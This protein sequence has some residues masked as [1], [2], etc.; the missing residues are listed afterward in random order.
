MPPDFFQKPLLE[1]IRFMVLHVR[2]G[3]F[4]IHLWWCWRWRNNFVFEVVAWSM[5]KVRSL[6]QSAIQDLSVFAASSS[7]LQNTGAPSSWTAPPAAWVKLNVD[8]S[9]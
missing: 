2:H 6:I 9:C 3:A 7:L 5:N 1:W 8:G 4:L